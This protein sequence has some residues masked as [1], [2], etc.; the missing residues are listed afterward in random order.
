MSD[1]DAIFTDPYGDGSYAVSSA[2]D[3]DGDGLDDI[4]IG[5]SYRDVDAPD[6]G[7]AYVIYGGGAW[8]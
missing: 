8:Q 4:L 6:Q 2:G 7:A 1:A 3:L 5:D